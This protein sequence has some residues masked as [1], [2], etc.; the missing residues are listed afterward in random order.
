MRRC[1]LRTECEGWWCAGFGKLPGFL[2]CA[3]DACNACRQHGN[4]VHV[5]PGTLGVGIH[6]V[7]GIVCILP[8]GV[9]C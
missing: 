3:V 4:A 8:I 9:G 1:R 7:S 6:V 5:V 2:G